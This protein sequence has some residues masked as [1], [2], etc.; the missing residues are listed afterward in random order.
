M[1]N[2]LFNGRTG[3]S[4]SWKRLLGI[5]SFRQK[6]AR[7]TGIPTTLNGLQRKIGGI[8]LKLFK[9]NNMGISIN[10]ATFKGKNIQVRDNKVYL[11]GKLQ[12]ISKDT[13][14]V[15]IVVNGDINSIEVDV[16][17]NIEVSGNAT[18]IQTVNGDVKIEGQVGGNIKTVNGDV[19]T[20]GSILGGVKTVNGDIKSK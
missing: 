2:N 12:P 11:D 17:E 18:D 8:L 13:K 14:I 4:F 5:T 19:K 1:A 10:G 6:I 9:Q 7:S 20:K 15:N 16:C 3:M